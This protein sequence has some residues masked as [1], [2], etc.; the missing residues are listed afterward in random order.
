M[1]KKSAGNI[2]EFGSFF[3]NFLSDNISTPHRVAL[4]ATIGLLKGNK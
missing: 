2:E 4:N 3:T 1:S